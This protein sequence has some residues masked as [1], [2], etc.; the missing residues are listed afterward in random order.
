MKI[1]S[2]RE[3][4]RVSFMTHHVLLLLYTNSIL[5]HAAH[6][7]VDSDEGIILK[8]FNLFIYAE[9]DLP[10][11]VISFQCERAH[12]LLIKNS[13]A[14]YIFNYLNKQKHVYIK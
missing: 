12:I 13:R 7:R 4:E 9:F 2:E 14:V 10:S 8:N 3:R 5:M 6:T 11:F 1:I